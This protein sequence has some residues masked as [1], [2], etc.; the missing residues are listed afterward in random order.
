LGGTADWLPQPR[1]ERLLDSA[2]LRAMAQ[3]GLVEVGAH[4]CEHID[5]RGL[6]SRQLDRQTTQACELLREITGSPIRAFAYPFGAHDSEARRAVAQ[7]GCTIGF[8]VFEDDGRFAVS[9]V[10]VN[11]TDTM[12]SFRLKLVPAYRTWWRALGR[13]PLVRRLVR[14]R[15]TRGSVVAVGPDQGAG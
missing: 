9:R 2:R 15:L 3:E 13:V 11:A 5:M 7:A 14:R 8:S 12:S 6:D 1:D 4:A 10:D